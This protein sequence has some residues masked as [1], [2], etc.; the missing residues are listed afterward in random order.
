MSNE[1][2]PTGDW[3]DMNNPA[4]YALFCSYEA[5]NRRIKELES[6]LAYEQERNAS[7]VANAGLQIAE[8]QAE[9]TRLRAGGCARD[10]HTTQYCGETGRLVER[11]TA[12]A[13]DLDRKA[14]DEDDERYLIAERIREAIGGGDEPRVGLL[15]I[16]DAVINRNKEKTMTIQDALKESNLR[17]EDFAAPVLARYIRQVVSF[18]DVVADL[19]KLEAT[20]EYERIRGEIKRIIN[21]GREPLTAHNPET[22]VKQITA[23][24]A[25]S[26]KLDRLWKRS[27]Q[28]MSVMFPDHQTEGSDD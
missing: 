13:D 7:N 28:L 2:T 18:R 6:Q 26:K 24:L 1:L 21:V 5:A 9:I 12:L 22:L 20:I 10:Q 16:A 14:M 19:T 15:D 3:E 4:Y 27:D 23:N 8:L 17:I 11:L 25:E